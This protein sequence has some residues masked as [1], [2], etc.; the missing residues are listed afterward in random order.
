MTAESMRAVVITRVG[1]PDVLVV[2]EVER[3]SRVPEKC[4]SGC[5]L[6]PSIVPT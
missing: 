5:A 3:P 4:W 1:A 6:P 2:R